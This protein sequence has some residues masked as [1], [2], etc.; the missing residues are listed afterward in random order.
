MFPGVDFD[1]Y[2]ELVD[3]VRREDAGIIGYK[4]VMWPETSILTISEV[5]EM[6]RL[7]RQM[8]LA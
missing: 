8:V 6:Q 5:E 4:N 1:R 2:R 3:G 7:F